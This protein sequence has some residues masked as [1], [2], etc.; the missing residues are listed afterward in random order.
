VVGNPRDIPVALQELASV[1]VVMSAGAILSGAVVSETV[2][3]YV[4]DTVFPAASVTCQ[5]TAVI[6]KEKVAGALFLGT[7]PPQLSVAEAVPIVT[8]QFGEII[9][10]GTTR[11]GACWSTTVIFW[12]ITVVLLALSVIVHV[13]IFSPSR[14]S[15]LGLSFSIE[16]IAQLSVAVTVPVLKR[17]VVQLSVSV[18][19]VRS[20]GKITLG[21]IV[22]LAS[23]KTVF[24]I[25]TILPSVNVVEIVTE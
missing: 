16:L 10:G 20:G 4:E 23:T 11:T 21:E 18:G 9:S 1:V 15:K 5:V 24:E 25:P 22:S 3:N 17:I 7:K 14:K 6:P 12:V 19:T 8:V 2:T 13:K